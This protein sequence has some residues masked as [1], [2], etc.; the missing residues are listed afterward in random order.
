MPRPIRC[1]WDSPNIGAANVGYAAAIAIGRFM[2]TE[3]RHQRHRI[4]RDA[5]A[6]GFRALNHEQIGAPRHTPWHTFWTWQKV[7]PA[8]LMRSIEGC[9]VIALNSPFSQRFSKSTLC[10]VK[11]VFPRNITISSL[12][13]VRESFGNSRPFPDAY[14]GLRPG[15]SDQ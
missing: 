3:R 1:Q 13:T 4:P 6:A 5:M 12:S 7:A 10:I 9:R 15:R 14:C 8:P 11:R 2:S